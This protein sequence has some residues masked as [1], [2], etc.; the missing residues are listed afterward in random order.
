MGKKVYKAVFFLQLLKK[1]MRHKLT[2][3]VTV[4]N[5]KDGKLRLRESL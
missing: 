1:K 5:F 2:K 3:V 4:P